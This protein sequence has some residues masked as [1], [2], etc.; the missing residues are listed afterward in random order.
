MVRGTLKME[1]NREVMDLLVGVMIMGITPSTTMPMHL[2]HHTLTFHHTPKNMLQMP[3][4]HRTPKNIHHTT[5]PLECHLSITLLIKVKVGIQ[6]CMLTMSMA[7]IMKTTVRNMMVK[8]LIKNN[9]LRMSRW[10][11]HPFAQYK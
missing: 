4:F 3:T 10:F 5:H 7:I 9:I 2:E 11:R 1:D 6:E 8:I